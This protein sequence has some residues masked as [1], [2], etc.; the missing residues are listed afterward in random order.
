MFARRFLCNDNAL[1]VFCIR[2]NHS[3]G[4][5]TGVSVT[6][7]RRGF[8]QRTG[9]RV[10]APGSNQRNEWGNT[11]KIKSKY[12]WP[13][14]VTSIAV[15]SAATFSAGCGTYAAQ[16][17]SKISR[18]DSAVQE[19]RDANAS[20]LASADLQTASGNVTT[21]KQEFERGDYAIAQRAADN[22]SIQGQ[23]ATA[24]A[25]LETTNQDIIAKE[26]SIA[27]EVMAMRNRIDAKNSEIA[28]IKQQIA[29]VDDEVSKL[30]RD[31]TDIQNLPKP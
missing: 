4:G 31:L 24:R 17:Q 29:V 19:A 18:G 22:A 3:N 26:R 20:K 30:N 10:I 25:K 11:V 9:G 23:V 15:L 21:A 14:L 13:R 6:A 5:H 12:M 2:S 7:W 27:P 16:T 1:Q 8:S 28:T